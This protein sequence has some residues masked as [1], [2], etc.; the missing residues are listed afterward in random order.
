M[1]QA[2]ASQGDHCNERETNLVHVGENRRVERTLYIIDGSVIVIN[3]EILGE[4]RNQ[5]QDESVVVID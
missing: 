5:L 4:V 2:C 3:Q 1:C